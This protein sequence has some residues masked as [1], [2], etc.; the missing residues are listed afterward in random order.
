MSSDQARRAE[1]ALVVQRARV[2]HV[3]SVDT[4]PDGEVDDLDHHGRTL[5]QAIADAV[6]A[7][8]RADLAAERALADQ[9]AVALAAQG[10]ASFDE[11]TNLNIKRLA[12]DAFK[13]ARRE[14]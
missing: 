11:D 5:D 4:L 6:L 8:E 14:Q 2:A 9:L 13:D 7:A 3:K 12:L 10:S 1:I